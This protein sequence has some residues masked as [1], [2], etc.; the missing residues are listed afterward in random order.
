MRPPIAFFP[1]TVRPKDK[2][3]F[4]IPVFTARDTRSQEYNRG[5]DA[6]DPVGAPFFITLSAEQARDEQAIVDAILEQYIRL[7][8]DST[9]MTFMRAVAPPSVEKDVDELMEEEEASVT[10]QGEMNVEEES[11]APMQIYA[12]GMDVPTPPTTS[13]FPDGT[14]AS[15][16]TPLPST[17]SSS[18]AP[19]P[20]VIDPTLVDGASAAVPISTA[21]P[22]LRTLFEP[23]VFEERRNYSGSIPD[24]KDLSQ[25]APLGTPFRGRPAVQRPLFGN[26][27][28]TSSDPTSDDD[29]DDE[30][31]P[32]SLV[33]HGMGIVCVWSKRDLVN[34]LGS[35]SSS[36]FDMGYEKFV[37][38]S[39][40][41]EM[42][43]RRTK[44]VLSIQDCLDEFSKEETLGE[45]D[46]WYCS[47]V[48]L[49][50]RL[51][52]FLPPLG[53]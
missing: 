17:H 33:Q 42:G 44:A 28:D 53:D 5:G 25:L 21:L 36:A 38:P 51:T 19:S 50:S 41:A 39:L 30:S 13:I 3:T 24:G 46:L 26:R 49:S 4:V 2:S 32:A 29:T 47:N 16:L 23:F 48:S 15:D 10:D 18:T 34:L 7:V 52:M 14:I 20:T 8:P 1:Q 45:D 37:D 31:R 27:L 35:K 12:S 43:K 11:V 40:A 6:P 9:P 22:Q